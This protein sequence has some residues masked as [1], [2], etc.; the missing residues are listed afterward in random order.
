MSRIR[1]MA[2]RLSPRRDADDLEKARRRAR[3]LR[4]KLTDAE[5]EIGRLR[6]EIRLTRDSV[7]D[8]F[9]DLSLPE[10]VRTCI[11]T[12]TEEHLSYLGRPNLAVL[13]RLVR[14]ADMAKR[15]G[16]VLEAGTARGG[17]AIVM[18]AAKEPGRAMKVYDVF[19][20][21]P[22]PSEHDDKDVHRRYAKIVEGSS[23]GVGG[24]TYYGYRDDLFDEV[25]ESFAR[26]GVPVG[27]NN[28][29]LVKGL[30]QDT[31]ELDGPVALAHV[32]GDW[33]ESTMVCLERIVPQLV[34]GGRIVVDDYYA[35]SGCRTAVD[36]Y[37]A[38]RPGLRI[39]RRSK[40][41]IVRV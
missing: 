31:I 30:F 3:R 12:V 15:E 8:P 35:W 34:T 10:S 20:M 18:A 17:S 25:T 39:E 7:R 13:A 4:K 11:D 41:H 29:E 36:E 5:A 21:I 1:T 33:Y 16:A 2:S 37:V 23:K 22:A 32:D 28:V 38:G 14:E 40:L 9:P 26:L 24:E 27:D 6:S 19:G